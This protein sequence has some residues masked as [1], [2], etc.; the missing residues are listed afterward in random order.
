M[1]TPNEMVATLKK[2]SDTSRR[3]IEAAKITAE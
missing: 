1:L 2:E 3:I